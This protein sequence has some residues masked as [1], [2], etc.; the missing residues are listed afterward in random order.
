MS[1]CEKCWRDSGGN[2]DRYAELL[3]ERATHVC[4]AEEQ[5]GDDA[6]ECPVC[7]RKTVHQYTRRPLCRCDELVNEP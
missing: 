2:P 6:T 1:A 4:T 7:H 5:A 3:V